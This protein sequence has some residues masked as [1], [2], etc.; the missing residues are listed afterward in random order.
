METLTKK[1]AAL[2]ATE[3]AGTETSAKFV[4]EL[5]ITQN[6]SFLQDENLKIL[7]ENIEKAHEA[8]LNNPQAM[9]HFHKRGLTDETIKRFRLV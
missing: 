9:E 8:A 6:S 1:E 7:Q 2:T 5:I 4:S 3:A